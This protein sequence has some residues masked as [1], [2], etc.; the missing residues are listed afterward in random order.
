M[1]WVILSFYWTYKKKNL[2][3]ANIFRVKKINY[4]EIDSM[5]SVRLDES[6]DNSDDR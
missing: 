3:I 4:V 5:W 2:E 1:L 6:K